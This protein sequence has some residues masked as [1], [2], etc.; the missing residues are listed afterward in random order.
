MWNCLD[1]WWCN[2]YFGFYSS[3]SLLWSSKRKI[4]NLETKYS[5]C[6]GST[7]STTSIRAGYFVIGQESDRNLFEI[8]TGNCQLQCNK[9]PLLS[10]PWLSERVPRFR[11]FYNQVH[12]FFFVWLPRFPIFSKYLS[13][14]PLDWNGMVNYRI[15][16][17]WK[18]KI[19]LQIF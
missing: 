9:H 3:V 15:N 1:N 14:K 16:F 13:C 12:I 2:H 8:S 7:W 19:H 4:V 17:L 10:L 6:N 18:L 5:S 11:D